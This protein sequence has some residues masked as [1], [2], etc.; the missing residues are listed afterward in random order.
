MKNA[1]GTLIT[2]Q[3]ELK[4]ELARVTAVFFL[5]SSSSDSFF[6]CN[7]WSPDASSTCKI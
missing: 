7:T 6:V 1:G 2:I 5:I 3:Y 4:I